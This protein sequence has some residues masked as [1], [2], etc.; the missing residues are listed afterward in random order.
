MPGF[1]YFLPTAR[2]GECDTPEQLSRWGLS[3]LC[4]D[5]QPLK[6]RG[7]TVDGQPGMMVGSS[8][9]WKIEDM[10][11]GEHVQWVKFPRAFAE[12]Q[13][14]L[15]IVKGLQLPGPSDLKRANQI[16]GKSITLEDGNRWLVPNARVITS[17]GLRCSLPV[18]FG[19]D[20]ETGDWISDQ[21][22]PR[23]RPI[24]QHA[25]AYIEAKL[26]AIEKLTEENSDASFSIPDGQK[27]VADALQVNY[28][29]SA[30]ELA[31]LGVLVTGLAAEIA[32]ILIDADGLERLKKKEAGATGPG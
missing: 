14:S 10:K 9:N 16:S 28:R 4:D 23:Y 24:W 6:S 2:Q 18:S 22:L 31:T 30:R 1:L 15:G 29:V 21:V 7:C 17:E 25:N 19:L 12:V 8:A 32:E 13:A 20:E 26:A 11:N 3:Y 27:L 5:C